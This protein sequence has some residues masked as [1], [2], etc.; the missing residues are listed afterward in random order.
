MPVS[1]DLAYKGITVAQH[2]TRILHVRYRSL[3]SLQRL[4]IGSKKEGL[5]DIDNS[6]RFWPAA[7]KLSKSLCLPHHWNDGD[8]SIALIRVAYT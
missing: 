4:E 8:D 1:G 2:S 5:R 7:I 3:A 6:L